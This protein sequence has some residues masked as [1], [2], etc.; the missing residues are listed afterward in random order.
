MISF[1]SRWGL[2]RSTEG[3]KYRRLTLANLNMEGYCSIPIYNSDLH[4]TLKKIRVVLIL[5]FKLCDS[6]ENIKHSVKI[7]LG[8]KVVFFNLN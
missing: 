4:L 1:S 2:E 7:K 8:K 5:L 3:N 6:G